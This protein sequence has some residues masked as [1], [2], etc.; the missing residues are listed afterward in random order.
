MGAKHPWRVSQMLRS[1]AKALASKPLPRKFGEWYAI[2]R[3]LHSS[4]HWR[5]M[6]IEADLC[7][8]KTA[9]SLGKR[10]PFG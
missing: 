6:N 5:W 8:V 3:S 4:S 1:V 2:E 10:Y 9:I 7:S